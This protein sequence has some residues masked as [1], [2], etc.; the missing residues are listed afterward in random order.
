MDS[1]LY[2]WVLKVPPT[3]EAVLAS[4]AEVFGKGTKYGHG[5]MGALLLHFTEGPAGI[6]GYYNIS[7]IFNGINLGLS[8]RIHR[9]IP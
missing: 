7:Y 4:L 2:A 8:L 1:G 3:A 5:F 6:L 9:T